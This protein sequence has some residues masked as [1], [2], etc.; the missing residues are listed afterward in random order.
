MDIKG[1]EPS[2]RIWN[3]VQYTHCDLGQRRGFFLSSKYHENNQDL[4][5]LKVVLFAK[6]VVILFSN[7]QKHVEIEGTEAGF[8]INN[9]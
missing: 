9:L 1:S 8:E 6:K 2:D 5:N 3:N 7:L 4:S